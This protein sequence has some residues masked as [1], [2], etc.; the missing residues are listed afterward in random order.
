VPNPTWLRVHPAFV[1]NGR[2][3]HDNWIHIPYGFV[4]TCFRGLYQVTEIGLSGPL[5]ERL[6]RS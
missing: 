3:Q 4:L 2:L 6:E 5:K 1:V